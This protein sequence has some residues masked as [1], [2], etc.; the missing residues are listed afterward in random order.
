MG[1]QIVKKFMQKNPKYTLQQLMAAD[2]E[3]I[4]QQGKYKP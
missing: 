3:T 1:W 2:A 4:F